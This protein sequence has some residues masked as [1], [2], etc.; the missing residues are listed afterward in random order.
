MIESLPSLD[1]PPELHLRVL[2]RLDSARRWNSLRDACRCRVCGDF[3]TGSEIQI[4]G[5]TRAYGPLRLH[6]P[7]LRCPVGPE[8]WESLSA[9]EP[10]KRRSA[11]EIIAAFQ[12]WVTRLRIVFPAAVQPRAGV[13]ASRAAA[14]ADSFAQLT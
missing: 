7:G 5:G 3:F 2:R 13:Q 6:C 8:A 12:K 11:A 10:A 9:A 1:L 14:S 4:V